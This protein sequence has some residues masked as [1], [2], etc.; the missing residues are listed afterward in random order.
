MAVPFLREDHPI[1]GITVGRAHVGPF[2]E[3]QI[4]LLQSL[5]EQAVI[6]IE[7]IRLFEVEQTSTRELRESREYQTATAGP[8]PVGC[9]SF[10]SD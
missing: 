7:N 4:R 2:P 1:G 6:A 5:A 8:C 3:D 10:R 9:P